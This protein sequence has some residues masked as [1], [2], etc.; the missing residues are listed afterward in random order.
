MTATT[1]ARRSSSTRPHRETTGRLR[2]TN[3]QAAC[4]PAMDQDGRHCSDMLDQVAA[5]RDAVPRLI[6][7]DHMHTPI[8]QA[9]ADGDAEAKRDEPSTAVSQHVRSR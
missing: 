3:R 1:S 8:R 9:V 7:E 6:R 4:V 2:T 5:A